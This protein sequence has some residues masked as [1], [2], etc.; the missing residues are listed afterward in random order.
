MDS[1]YL[2]QGL[3]SNGGRVTWVILRNVLLNLAHKVS[4]HV[5]SLGVDSTTNTSKQSN[6]GS[7]QTVT[8]DGLIKTVPVIAKDLH[9]WYMF[10][11][12]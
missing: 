7:T 2:E 4:T 9:M 5:S 1:L 10:A 11:P 8:C 6:G 3:T 12:C